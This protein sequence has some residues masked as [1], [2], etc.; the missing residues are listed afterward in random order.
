MLQLVKLQGYLEA[1]VICDLMIKA[2]VNHCVSDL[3]TSGKDLIQMS[4][5]FMGN[6]V[7]FQCALKAKEMQLLVHVVDVVVKVT[8]Y[9]NVGI[10][11]LFDDILDDISHQLCYI[12]LELLITR[13][14][15]AV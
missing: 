13:F 5:H 2:I 12:L 3:N 11:I 7:R 1:L 4:T 14:K 8:T 10:G 9:H 15:I 6:S